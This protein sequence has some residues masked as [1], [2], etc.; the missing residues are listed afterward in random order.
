MILLPIVWFGLGLSPFAGGDLSLEFFA[1]LSLLDTALIAILIRVFLGVGGETSSA[2]FLGARPVRGEILRG[3]LL[4]PVVFVGVTA[5][6]IGLRAVA[7]WLQTVPESPL[8][9]FMRTPLE[10]AIFLVVV[11]LAGGVREEL[12]RAFIL[13]RVQH[14]HF[15]VRALGRVLHIGGIRQ[16]LAVFSITFGL[17][18]LDQ[19]ADVALAIGMLGLFWGILYV[20]R[21]SAV[22]AMVNH[23][24]FNALQVIQV[25]AARSLG[26]L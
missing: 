16:G 3:L 7:P 5:I 18:H 1:V 13:H 4:V 2:V 10:A 17:L 8:E 6:V 22:T 23:A 20:R 25:M 11:V 15:H 19:G 21:R 12:Q 24:G 9:D 26:G 14:V